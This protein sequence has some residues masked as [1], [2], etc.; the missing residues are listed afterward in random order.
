VLRGNI[1]DHHRY[2]LSELMADLDFITEKILRVE[3]EIARRM[4][5]YLDQVARLCTIPGV[6]VLTA[7]TLIAELGPD[8]SV[9]PTAAHAA[10]W[11]GLCPGNR[12]SAGKRLGNRTKKGNRWL[13]RALCQAAWGL[14]HKKDCYLT[15]LFL[16]RAAKAGV[17]K[18][19][20]ATAHQLLV[21][22]YCL[23]R[24]R[25][26]YRELGGG[27]RPAQPHTHSEP[28]SPP[29]GTSWLAGHSQG[30]P[31]PHPITGHPTSQATPWSTLPVSSTRNPLQTQATINALFR[32]NG[33]IAGPFRVGDSGLLSGGGALSL[34][35]PV[36]REA[37]RFQTYEML[38]YR[39][40]FRHAALI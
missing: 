25:S 32:R 39:S 17:K 26:E 14:S 23:L 38:V 22:A 30:C 24:D 16:R 3:A 34:V 4:E 18:A 29:I 5:S 28:P 12:E 40:E 9:F 8:M 31:P 20:I 21:I 6:D 27:F 19:I 1:R 33:K 13:R 10:S 15:A 36:V 35:G 2:L 7:W 11:A 37:G